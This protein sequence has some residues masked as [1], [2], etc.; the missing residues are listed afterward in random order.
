MV[1]RGD[2]NDT[3]RSEDRSRRGEGGGGEALTASFS[4]LSPLPPSPFLSSPLAAALCNAAFCKLDAR[5]LWVL[6]RD[7]KLTSVA[8]AQ[9]LTI[10]LS[11][12]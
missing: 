9:H 11:L 5:M 2:P 6:F 10:S 7:C 3:P 1:E 12:C 8:A 4:S